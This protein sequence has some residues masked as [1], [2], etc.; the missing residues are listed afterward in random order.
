MGSKQTRRRKQNDDEEIGR[1]SPHQNPSKLLYFKAD[2]DK[3]NWEA[4][5]G[6]R[7]K[8]FLETQRRIIESNKLTTF[9][10]MLVPDKLS[11]YEPWIADPALGSL[12][13]LTHPD[14]HGQN[15]LLNLYPYITAAIESG[16]KDFYLPNDTHWSPEGDR[17]VAKWVAQWLSDPEGFSSSLPGH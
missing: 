1:T 9:L 10:S 15:R 6:S 13:L 17:R 16:F 2:G 3:A 14:L 7:V 12:S 4:K 8:C 11:G 5:T